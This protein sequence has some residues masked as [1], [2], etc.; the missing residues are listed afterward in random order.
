MPQTAVGEER[1]LH[2]HQE[3]AGGRIAQ[4]G[5]AGAAVLGDGEIV[6][7]AGGPQRVVDVAPQGRDA[8]VGRDGGHQDA[9]ETGVRGPLH[10]GHCGVDVAEEDLGEAGPSTGE[11][12]A[13]VGQ[14]PVVGAQAGTAAGALLGGARRVGDE[15]ARGEE[16]R[17]RVGE[18][19][20][21][22]DAVRLEVALAH[23]AVP[24]AL[25]SG[26]LEV[27]PGVDEVA[28]PPVELVEPVALEVGPVG[29]DVGAGVPVGRHDRVAVSAHARDDNVGSHARDHRQLGL[30]A[31][32]PSR[33]RRDRRGVRQGWGA[34]H[35]R[36][37][38]L[39]RGHHHHGRRRRPHRPGRRGRDLPRCVV[40]RHLDARLPREDQRHHHPCR[41]PVA[42]VGRSPR[43]RWCPPLRHRRSPHRP[44]GSWHHPRGQCR[45][46]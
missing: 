8:L 40:V 19:H 46:A 30:R 45:T 32:P 1:H 23:L 41:A 21:G 7:G 12:A 29:V 20:L 11:V 35:S 42:P 44:R 31:P 22:D 14:P 43:S 24:V 25:A 16:R 10:L 36:R 26:G 6:V 2:Q 27:G 17:D 15:H 38:L 33:S 13:P 39:R 9:L 4:V 37:G 28:P 34:R 18:Q 5:Q 3:P